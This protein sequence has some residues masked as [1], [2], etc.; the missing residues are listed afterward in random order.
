MK[1]RFLAG[2]GLGY[3]LG[4]RAGRERYD[5]IMQ[6]LGGA[7]DSD[8]ITSLRSELSKL[9][10]GASATNPGDSLA[11]PPVIVGPGPDGATGSPDTDVVLPD[12][13]S[14]NSASISGDTPAVSDE[15]S[16]ARRLDPPAGG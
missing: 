1:L 13:E 8:L 7:A 4:T 15:D 6:S 14:S 5:Q 11:T 3:L 2:I 12:L 9:T 10:G 16:P